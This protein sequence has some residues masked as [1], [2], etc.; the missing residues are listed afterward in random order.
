[1]RRDWLSVEP[2]HEPPEQLHGPSLQEH[3]A[4]ILLFIKTSQ[5]LNSL[6]RSLNVRA[7]KPILQ[8]CVCLAAITTLPNTKVYFQFK[9]VK[10]M[11]LT[12]TSKY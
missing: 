5:A 6:A 1:M 8:N 12:I 2:D 4:S 11:N 7:S 10:V 9:L 3:P